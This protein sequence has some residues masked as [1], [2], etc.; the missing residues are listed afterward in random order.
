MIPITDTDGMRLP[1]EAAEWLAL[2]ISGDFEPITPTAE[3]AAR[4]GLTA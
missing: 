2:V 3:E 1:D 4:L